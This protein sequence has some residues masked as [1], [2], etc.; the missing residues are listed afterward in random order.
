MGVLLH[1]Q[2]HKVSWPLPKLA[3]NWQPVCPLQMEFFAE[4]EVI[5]V[6]PNVSFDT[7]DS[8]LICIG[9]T[10]LQVPYVQS[11]PDQ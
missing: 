4:E 8:S 2:D 6:I 3:P 5:T 10:S 1:G 9:V 11:S 7:T